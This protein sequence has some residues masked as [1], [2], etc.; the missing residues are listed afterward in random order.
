[1]ELNIGNLNLAAQFKSSLYNSQQEENTNNV[2]NTAMVPSM[3]MPASP[4]LNVVIPSGL[5]TAF[6]EPLINTKK[7]QDVKRRPKT[8]QN[9]GAVVQ[10]NI[11]TVQQKRRILTGQKRLNQADSV[12][13]S[14]MIVMN[15]KK[16]S[17][18]AGTTTKGIVSLYN[19]G[20]VPKK[21]GMYSRATKFATASR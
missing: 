8:A 16:M 6:Q 14:S 17:V 2:Y 1:M 9:R 12:A 3:N 19:K 15:E 13:T 7:T 5:N 20:F 18:A 10:K 21:T 4:T 11:N